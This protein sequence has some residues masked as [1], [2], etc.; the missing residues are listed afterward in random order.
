MNAQKKK[1]LIVGA[2]AK[3]GRYANLAAYRLLQHGH[4]IELL[5]SREGDI[6]G[7][8]IRTGEPDLQGIDTVTMY[9]GP[10]N[11]PKLYEYIKRLKP[12]RVIFNPGAE[13]PEFDKQLRAEG[14][15]TIEA[16][17]LV[18]LSVGTY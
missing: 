8:P 2:T 7:H 15:E 4:T 6:E 1:T 17:T 9:V 3:A 16:C 11:Q 18:M 10:Q 13:N 5:G 12:K 14:V